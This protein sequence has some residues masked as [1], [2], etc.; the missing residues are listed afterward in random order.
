MPI[1]YRLKLRDKILA[2]YFIPVVFLFVL[3]GVVYHGL[4]RSDETIRWVVHTY[5]VIDAAREVLSLQVDMETGERGFVIT[6]QEAFLDG[7]S[8][9]QERFDESV[10]RVKN[11]VSDNPPQVRRME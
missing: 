8:A 4:A 3:A 5:D 7:F 6:G 1:A 11:L 9:A 2:G 10:N